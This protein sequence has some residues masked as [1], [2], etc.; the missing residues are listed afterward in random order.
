MAFDVKFHSQFSAFDAAQWNALSSIDSPFLRA[1][2]LSA[3]EESECVG[4]KTG[5]LPH[6]V[7][8]YEDSRLI[9]AM[10]GYIKLDSYGEYVFDHAWANA[11]FQHGLN[12]YPKWISAIPFTPVPGNRLLIQTGV[13]SAEVF[14]SINLALQ[15]LATKNI[16]STHVLFPHSP[17]LLATCSNFLLRKSVQFHWHNY[18]YQSFADFL[19][20]L[21]SRKRKSIRKTRR[22]LHAQGISISRYRGEEITQSH[23]AFFYQ[24]YRQTYLKRSGHDG[25]LTRSFFNQIYHSMRE[26][27]LIVEATLAGNPIASSL[28]FFDSSGLYGRYWG[29]VKHIEELHFECCYFQG[30]EFAIEQKLATFNP[31]TQGEHKILRGFE[32]TFCY[33]LHWLFHPEFSR[34]VSQF[35]IREKGT[36]ETY[37]EQAKMV[38]P[39]NE[40]MK[41]HLICNT[42]NSRNGPK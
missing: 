25:Y 35:L 20:A 15:S 31:G 29:C 4:K 18:H 22:Q 21:T 32:P 40:S 8:V 12:Y 41:D 5:W 13:D 28:F 9:A 10:P 27:I 42:G 33:S 14:E 36:V 7:G 11:Y 3:L 30:I 34:A 23:M 2:F 1:E 16:S 17:D 26:H 37:F 24:C 6:H 39:Y 19:G 38:L